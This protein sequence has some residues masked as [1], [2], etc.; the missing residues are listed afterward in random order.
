MKTSRIPFVL[1]L[2]IAF[3]LISQTAIAGKPKPKP[4]PTPHPPNKITAISEDSITI[5]DGKVKKTYKINGDTEITYNG[6]TATVNTL[7]VGL[8]VDVVV[9]LDEGVAARIATFDARQ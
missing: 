6:E 4:K 8:R 1:L 3:V 7:T 2:G 9:G 5:S